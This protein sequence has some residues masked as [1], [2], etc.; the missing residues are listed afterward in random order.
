MYGKIALDL[1]GVATDI[2]ADLG[3][4]DIDLI[5]NA[6]FTQENPPELDPVFANPLFWRNLKPI[7]DSWHRINEWFYGGFDIF[8]V[9]ARRS[10][11][12]INEIETWLDGWNI[13]FNKVFVCNQMEKTEVLKQINPILFIDDNPFEVEKIISEINNAFQVNVIKNWYNQHLIGAA[14][15][16]INSLLEVEIG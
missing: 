14:V 9:T 10:D 4:K 7:K 11:E 16:S 3:T 12:S 6:L 1:D 15:P 5:S 2:A 8:F 13:P